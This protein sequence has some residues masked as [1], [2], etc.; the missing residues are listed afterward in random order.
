[1]AEADC[2]AHDHGKQLQ[3]HDGRVAPGHLAGFF[4]VLCAPIDVFKRVAVRYCAGGMVMIFLQPER[5]PRPG[6]AVATKGEWAFAVPIEVL[7]H[8]RVPAAAADCT[9]V[10]TKLFGFD[11]RAKGACLHGFGRAVCPQASGFVASN[12]VSVNE[13]DPPERRVAFLIKRGHIP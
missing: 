12:A 11:L 7:R 13:L 5:Q 6:A 9:G 4:L 2:F 10:T 8:P 1:M 3:F